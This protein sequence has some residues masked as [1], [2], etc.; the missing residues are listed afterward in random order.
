MRCPPRSHGFQ[1]LDLNPLRFFG[2][3]AIEF[4]SAIAASSHSRASYEESQQPV[5]VLAVQR[6]VTPIPCLGHSSSMGRR[7]RNGKQ[8]NRR[9]GERRWFAGTMVQHACAVLP[10]Q[11]LRHPIL[12]FIIVGVLTHRIGC[13]H[14]VERAFPAG[15]HH[16][17]MECHRFGA[18]PFEG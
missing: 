15:S 16:S 3:A 7:V 11:S 18:M 14:S 10:Q 1:S 2:G 8:F 9:V 6:Q 17:S 12:P 5:S 4:P 13:H